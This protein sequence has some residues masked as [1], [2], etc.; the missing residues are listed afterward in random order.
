MNA[1]PTE[2]QIKTAILV[3]TILVNTADENAKTDVFFD[4]SEENL[5]KALI[6]YVAVSPNFKGE[7]YE[8][9]LGT[10]YDLLTKLAAQE[11][12]LEE[13]NE[14]PNNDPAVIPWRI[15]QGAGR[16]KPNFITGLT[17][18]L[19][20]F[21][22]DLVKEVFSHSEIDLLAPGR[23]KCGYYLITPVSHGKMKFLMSLFFSCAFEQLIDEAKENADLRLKIPTYFILDEFKA[24]GQINGFADKVANIRKHGISAAIIF[25]D[26]NQLQQQYKTTYKSILSNCDTHLVLKVNDTET[27]K[28]LSERIGITT[29]EAENTSY[30]KFRYTP[31]EPINPMEGIKVQDQRRML[32]NPDEIIRYFKYDDRGRK[33][34]VISSARP[35]YL[36]QTYDWHLHKLAKLAM[37]K[38][39]Q[40][41]AND[42]IPEW[43]AEHN[44]TMDKPRS[45]ETVDSFVEYSGKTK[46]AAYRPFPNQ[47]QGNRGQRPIVDN[48]GIEGYDKEPP[49][50][51]DVAIKKG[52]VFDAVD[53]S[54]NLMEFELDLSGKKKK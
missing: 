49:K 48:S 28:E 12:I 14:L 18:K 29:I 31:I 23:E 36:I 8:R 1:D 11:G 20:I 26:L 38:E 52:I 4:Q 45:F 43:Q 47:G 42:Y 10:V 24:I 30:K 7:E 9:H 27:A 50:A 46:E 40:A 34:I 3:H 15:F 33:A 5:L 17:A 35:V 21:Q 44:L 13:F 2:V 53:K 32:M 16:L 19:E 54:D 39:Y 37:Q 41:R 51:I 6:L 22:T 25:Q